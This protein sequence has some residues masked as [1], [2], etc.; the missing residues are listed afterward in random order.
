MK[1]Q[2]GLLPYIGGSTFKPSD[3]VHAAKE[4][5]AKGKFWIRNNLE[6]MDVTSNFGATHFALHTT[7]TNEM[8]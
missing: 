5:L 2:T 8:I 1:R 3:I 6:L 7:L 4:N